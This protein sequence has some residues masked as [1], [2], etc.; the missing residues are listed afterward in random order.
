MRT[1]DTRIM[2]IM[3]CPAEAVAV[4]TTVCVHEHLQDEAACAEHLDTLAN[5]FMRCSP[6]YELGHACHL[7]MVAEVDPETGERR[8]LPR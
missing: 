2:F 3:E 5:G 6:C 8:A 1:C 4:R 7:M